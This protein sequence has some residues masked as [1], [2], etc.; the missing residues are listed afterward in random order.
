[1]FITCRQGRFRWIEVL[2]GVSVLAV[3]AGAHAQSAPT[4]PVTSQAAAGGQGA[5]GSRAPDAGSV[6]DIIVTARKRAENL[7]DV[8]V[9]ITAVT[10]ATLQQKNITQV[11]DIAKT[12]PNFTY[13]YGAANSLAYIRGFGSGSNAGFEQSLGKFVDNVSYGRDQDARL[14]IFDV[15]RVEVLK[16]PQVLTFGNSATV[17]AI[18]IATRKPGDAFEADGSIGY[19]FYGREVQAQTGVT[20]PLIEGVSFRLAGLFQDLDRGRFD[21]PVKDA[22]E[23]RTR[24]FAI[25]PTLRL[26]P[27]AGLD[28]VLRAEVDRAKDFGSSLVPTGQPLSNK[29]PAYPEVGDTDHRFVDYD[30][31]PFY[32]SE[33]QQVDAELYQADVNYHLLGGTLTSTTAWRKT[34]A[35]VQW[36]TDGVDHETTYF[37]PQ[38]THYQQFSQEVRFSGSYG[39]FDVTAG[40]YYQRDTL[41]LD[42]AQEFTLGGLGLTGAA[43]TPFARVF[44][45]DQKDRVLSGFS[46][47]TNHLTN[48]LSISGGV[49][50]SDT[51]KTAGQSMFAANIIPDANFDT[52]RSTLLAARNPALDPVFAAVLGGVQHAFPMGAFHLSERH[53]QPQVIAQYKFAP[54]NM[55]Y[56]KYVKG[57]KVG[58][59][60]YT[61][62][63]AQPNGGFRPESAW[64]VEAGAKGLILGDRLDYSLALFRET[65][66]NLQQSVRQGFAF[67]VSN[68]G[69]A[70]AQGVELDLHYRV[71]DN[72]RV[73]LGGSYLDAKYIHFAGAA[74]NSLQNA[75]LAPGCS[76]SQDLSGTRTPYSSKWTGSLDV[77]YRKPIGSGDRQIGF[78]TSVYARTKYNSGAYND[79]RMIQRAYAQVDAH[80]DYGKVDGSWTLSVF[81]KDLNDKRLLEYSS[82]AVGSSTATFG[83]Y[84]RGR[85]VGLRLSFAM[86]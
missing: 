39:R 66:T 10:G 26:Q 84:S 12:T 62:S 47:L 53:W 85:Q 46:D 49:R 83:S 51:R 19:E 17:G 37:N 22:T 4:A 44:T 21:N 5:A 45:Y 24:N 80:V 71:D 68:V 36:G 70:R 42:V 48:S 25:R 73:G 30:V 31:A 78:G 60:D 79:P 50:Y 20:I 63:A 40:G 8:P 14:P 38:W 1:M 81:G 9:A 27:A 35:D 82:L 7:R 52:S 34:D 61:Y 74:C 32:S 57:D 6:G 11:I 69:K 16:G 23:P 33:F 13:T 77:D 18:N 54:R 15:E 28:I 59:F 72:L 3:A 41:H 56:A 2:A 55:V 75:G 86:H 43:A 76:G 64:M 29:L 58:G 65:F 67:I